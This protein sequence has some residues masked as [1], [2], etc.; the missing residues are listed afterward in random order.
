MPRNGRTTDTTEPNVHKTYSHEQITVAVSHLAPYPTTLYTYYFLAKTINIH[1]TLSPPERKIVC[2]CT[3]L[4]IIVMAMEPLHTR[5]TAYTL[6]SYT[7]H[8]LSS[9]INI[10]AVHSIQKATMH[11][12]PHTN[13]YPSTA[14]SEHYVYLLWN[15]DVIVG[16]QVHEF[17]FT[18]SSWKSRFPKTECFDSHIRARK[19]SYYNVLNTFTNPPRSPCCG[20]SDIAVIVFVRGQKHERHTTQIHT[21]RYLYCTMFVLKQWCECGYWSRHYRTMCFTLQTHAHIQWQI[22][23]TAGKIQHS[24]T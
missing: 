23:C 21:Y 1:H 16:A 6:Q 24:R 22:A 11:L 2:V 4:G 3:A 8:R 5:R 13:R 17:L 7:T 18:T 14:V 9:W 15:Y 12:G 20:A 10:H 19:H